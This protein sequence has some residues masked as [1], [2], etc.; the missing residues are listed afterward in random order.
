MTTAELTSEA[1][2]PGA[3][4]NVAGNGEQRPPQRECPGRELTR[5]LGELRAR[6]RH[7]DAHRPPR[8]LL[9][10]AWRVRT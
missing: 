10:P 6:D 3:R 8:A 1:R 5:P 2:P 7:R 9:A 4:Q